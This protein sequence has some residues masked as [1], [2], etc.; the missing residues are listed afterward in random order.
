MIRFLVLAELIVAALTVFLGVLSWLLLVFLPS[1]IPAVV[2]GLA[3]MVRPTLVLGRRRSRNTLHIASVVNTAWCVMY[4]VS[5]VTNIAEPARFIVPNG[6]TGS[7]AVVFDRPWG[8][9]PEYDGRRRIYRIPDDGVLA[10]RLEFDN[11]WQF[12]PVEYV[13]RT[14]V[15]V[16]TR[17]LI[18]GSGGGVLGGACTYSF[19]EFW[20]EPVPS[21]ARSVRDSEAFHRAACRAP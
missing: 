8:L 20:V 3:A 9:E 7:V 5:V 13:D 11:G 19:E 17:G 1:V 14:G 15:T 21:K 2:L 16:R 6:Y 18:V 12:S 4:M 10:T